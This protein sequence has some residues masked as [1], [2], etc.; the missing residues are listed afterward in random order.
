MA[1]RRM[2]SK[3]V[4][5]DDKFLD[6]TLA[7]RC[8]YYTLSMEADDD[9][10]VGAPQ[11]IMKISGTGPKALQALTDAGYVRQYASGVVSL[12]HWTMNNQIRKDRYRPTVY[13]KEKYCEH[14][15]DT[16]VATV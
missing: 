12:P 2:F 16:L 1:E 4:V 3:S 7:A 8:L 10:F 14:V 6:L 15:S 5:M 9:G 13:V 11:R